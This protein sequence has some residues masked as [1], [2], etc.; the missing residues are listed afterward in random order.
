M[1][2][3]VKKNGITFGLILGLLSIIITTL[4]Y[5]LDLTLFTNI[6]TGI[7]LFLVNIAIGIVVVAKTKKAMSGFISFK[8]SFTVF[9]I[10]MALGLAISN[11]FMMVLFNIIDTDAK[12]QLAENSIKM[13]VGFMQ[14]SGLKANDIAARVKEMQQTDGFSPGS[15]LISY[16]WGL[17]IYIIIGLLVAAV[18][19]K[20]NEAYKN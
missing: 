8:D 17:I 4:M 15:M 11:L 16:V 12:A 3:F 1:N 10:T 5:T 13:A 20:N 9:F 19:K 7:I 6:W 18:M 14:K 2:E